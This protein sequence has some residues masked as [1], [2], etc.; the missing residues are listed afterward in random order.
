MSLCLLSRSSELCYR[1]QTTDM[2]HSR[3]TTNTL[4]SSQTSIS[5][6]NLCVTRISSTRRSTTLLHTELQPLQMLSKSRQHTKQKYHGPKERRQ[7]LQNHWAADRRLLTPH[8]I[9]VE[10]E[11]TMPETAD[12]QAPNANSVTRQVTLRKCARRR[13]ATIQR[14][15]LLSSMVADQHQWIFRAVILI[16]AR[17]NNDN[18][19]KE[20]P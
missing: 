14:E 4:K 16:T 8:A 7:N 13:S 1:S 10:I 17:D 9:A 18:T 19:T 6:A 20:K 3:A 12:M 15:K 2:Q 5:S 11:V